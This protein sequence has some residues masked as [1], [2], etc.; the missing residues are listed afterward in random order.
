VNP[1]GDTEA[2]YHECLVDLSHE[3]T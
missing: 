1:E 3:E 2:G